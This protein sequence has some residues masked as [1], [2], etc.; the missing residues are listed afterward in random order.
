MLTVP[1]LK[2]IH[3]NTLIELKGLFHGVLPDKK[4]YL[5]CTH[6]NEGV[7][8]IFN[9]TYLGVNLGNVSMIVRDNEVEVS[10]V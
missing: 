1:D 3:V 5:K 9:A 10:E 2:K 6:A 7:D 8:Y 4:V